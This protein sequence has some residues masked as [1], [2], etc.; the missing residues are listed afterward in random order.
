LFA[1]LFSSYFKVYFYFDFDLELDLVLG[2][3][4][5][6]SL[7]TLDFAKSTGFFSYFP[8]ISFKITGS[9]SEELYP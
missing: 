1:C 5:L 7:K 9:E 8:L 6:D 2:F 4:L 3:E